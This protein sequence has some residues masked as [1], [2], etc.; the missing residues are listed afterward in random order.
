MTDERN[1]TE[2]APSGYNSR[3]G[4]YFGN[5][6]RSSLNQDTRLPHVSRRGA[7]RFSSADV[8]TVSHA[9]GGPN[10]STVSFNRGYSDQ[11]PNTYRQ[12]YSRPDSF[13][14]SYGGSNAYQQYPPQN[15][16]SQYGS[17]QRPRNDNRM[18]SDYAGNSNGQVFYPQQGYQR[19][20]DNITAGSGSGG[21]N[22]T[23]QW[24]NSTDPS[25]VNSSM[26]RLQQQ[27]QANSKQ[28]RP[29]AETYGINGFGPGP[30]LEGFTASYGEGNGSA[31]PAPP[32]HAYGARNGTG[33]GNTWYSN[34]GYRGSQQAPP[35]PAKEYRKPVGEEHFARKSTLRKNNSE[36]RQ[37]WFK[38]RFSKAD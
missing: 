36:K 29:L 26:D 2:A 10:A 16:Y 9:G 13:I 27:L 37:S 38:R 7:S 14:E 1:T 28:D 3:R 8:H 35:P 24:G 32:P 34:G 5:D 18:S 20:N 22:N 17:R 23:D 25:S 6:H 19:S 4:S 21:S 30:Q 31:P 33:N 12:S 11:G 15:P